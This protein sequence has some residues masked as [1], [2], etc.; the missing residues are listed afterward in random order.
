[1]DGQKLHQW[2]TKS[3][4][5][6]PFLVVHLNATSHQAI[7]IDFFLVLHHILHSTPGWEATSHFGAFRPTA[8]RGYAALIFHATIAVVVALSRRQFRF[9][10]IPQPL[11][12]NTLGMA[13]I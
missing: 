9:G 4:Y 11:P 1:M 10:P 6:S 5:S 2:I 8:C 3:H 12:G 13:G 7:T